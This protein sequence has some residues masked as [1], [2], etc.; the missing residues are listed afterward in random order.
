MSWQLYPLRTYPTYIC[1]Y[2]VIAVFSD[3]LNI[4]SRVAMTSGK[5]EVNTHEILL[6]V[7]GEHFKSCRRAQ[8]TQGS[9]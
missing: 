2:V 3:N 6:S 1:Y 5:V 9:M 4:I 7:S 8:S